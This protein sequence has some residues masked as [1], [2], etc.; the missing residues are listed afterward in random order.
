[1]NSILF[2]M[3]FKATPGMSLLQPSATPYL[4]QRYCA[5]FCGISRSAWARRRSRL[6]CR[7]IIELI[8]RVPL[9]LRDIY[10]TWITWID[11]GSTREAATEH[12]LSDV[13]CGLFAVLAHL[14]H[15]PEEHGQQCAAPAVVK[16]KAKLEIVKP[17]QLL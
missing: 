4:V 1:M 10:R 17:V 7:C 9:G 14:S 12:L 16:R 8:Y 3:S 5:R 13:V 15:D 11:I 6:R 2:L